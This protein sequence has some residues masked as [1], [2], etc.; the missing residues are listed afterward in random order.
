MPQAVGGTKAL[1]APTINLA[2]IFFHL[3]SQRVHMIHIRTYYLLLLL[4]LLLLFSFSLSG[5]DVQ[6]PHCGGAV[7]AYRGPID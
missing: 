1:V 2:F 7:R 5:G 4:L 3:P 6:A